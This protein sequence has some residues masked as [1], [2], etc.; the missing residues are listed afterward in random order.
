MTYRAQHH[1]VIAMVVAAIAI[2]M[3][4][5]Q[6][7]WVLAVSALFALAQLISSHQV[8]THI[9]ERRSPDAFCGLIDARPRAV[10]PFFARTIAECFPA[11]RARIRCEP[12]TL[13]AGVVA[14]S[15][16]IFGVT[17]AVA[18]VLK[19]RAARHARGVFLISKAFRL[20]PARAILRG[21]GA[22]CGDR[23]FYAANFAAHFSCHRSRYA[24]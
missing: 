3:V 16:T 4:N 9:G 18:G 13:K 20:T 7:F 5:T 10:H 8:F 15:R 12:R 23:E 17:L 19:V 14:F 21:C 24:A 11:M 1:Q 6:Y 22:I 2:F